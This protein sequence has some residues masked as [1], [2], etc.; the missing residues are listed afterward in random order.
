MNMAARFPNTLEFVARAMRVFNSVA[1][2]CGR[3]ALKKGA[4]QTVSEA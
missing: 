2:S 4:V 1:G 3:A